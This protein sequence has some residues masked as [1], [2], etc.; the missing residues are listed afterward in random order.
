MGDPLQVLY[1]EGLGDGLILSAVD[2]LNSIPGQGDWKL[3]AG[4]V[5]GT[6]ILGCESPE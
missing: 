1:R 5:G 2:K 6:M 3:M 4:S